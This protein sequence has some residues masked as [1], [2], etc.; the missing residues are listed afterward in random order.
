MGRLQDADWSL[1]PSSLTTGRIHHEDSKAQRKWSHHQDT[2]TPSRKGWSRMQRE[3]G[4]SWCL[5]VLVVNKS[6]PCLRVFVV[7]PWLGSGYRETGNCLRVPGFPP[8]LP[9]D[10]GEA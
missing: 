3:L 9:H 10:P 2:K 5:R 8:Q 6:S 4:S 1:R 7:R